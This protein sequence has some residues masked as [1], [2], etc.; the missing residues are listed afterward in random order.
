MNFLWSI[1]SMKLTKKIMKTK[2]GLW[3]TA[4]QFITSAH[5]NFS[6]FDSLTTS[7]N[8]YSYI[9]IYFIHKWN[10]KESCG[11]QPLNLSQVPSLLF[12][13][14]H[15]ITQYIFIYFSYFPSIHR[16][17]RGPVEHSCPIHHQCPP[18]FFTFRLADNLAIAVSLTQMILFQR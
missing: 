14:F 12:H 6:P 7:Y 5:L 15:Q 9:F 18:Y 17:R 8:M 11:E 13:L 1:I 10:Q 4:L 3:S 2:K 16:F